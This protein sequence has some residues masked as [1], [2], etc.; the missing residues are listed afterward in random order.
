MQGSYDD[1]RAD[2]RL[3]CFAPDVARTRAVGKYVRRKKKVG[4]R[5]GLGRYTTHGASASAH[6]DVV[7]AMARPEPVRPALTA[8][9]GAW[10]YWSRKM[11][12]WPVFWLASVGRRERSFRRFGLNPGSHDRRMS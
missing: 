12:K 3:N 1:E 8:A 11:A 2:W 9:R 10:S 5:A 4:A 7:G 6:F